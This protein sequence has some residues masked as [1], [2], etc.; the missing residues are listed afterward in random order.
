MLLLNTLFLVLLAFSDLAAAFYP[1][2]PEYRCIYDHT[3]PATKRDLESSLKIVQRLPKVFLSSPLNNGL[4]PELQV[5]RLA[6]RLTKKYQIKRGTNTHTVVAAATPSDTDSAGI[7]QDG[8]DYSYFAQVQLGSGKTPVYLLLDTGASQSWVMGPDCTSAPCLNHNSFGAPNSTTF[9][10]VEGSSWSVKYGSGSC[11]GSYGNDSLSFAG[12]TLPVTIGIANVTSNDFSNFPMDG[13][14][15]LSQASE[16][17]P[18]FTQSL[19]ASKT[20]KSNL[21]AMSLNRDSDGPNTG[22]ISFGSPDNTKYT[23]DIDY[24]SVSSNANGDWAISMDGIGFNGKDAG[25]TGK[26]AYIDTG[27]SYIFGPPS[28]VAQ[29]HAVVPG[30][31]SGDDYTYTVPCTTTVPLTFTFSG[32]TYN[33][34]SEDW[35]SPMAN[36][37]CTSNVFGNDIVAGQWLLGDTF[38][39]NVYTVFDIDGSRVGLALKPASSSVTSATSSGISSATGG[40]TSSMATSSITVSAGTTGSLSKTSSDSGPTGSPS[41]SSATATTTG[42]ATSSE[43]GRPGLNGHETPDSSG[44]A[45][46]ESSISSTA[47]P[48]ASPTKKSASSRLDISL[49]TMFLL[50]LAFLTL[51]F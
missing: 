50:A 4:S 39:K 23:G 31:A 9:E 45:A 32:V 47:S 46:A 28:E 38:L 34:S 14:L 7:D 5:R 35:V 37:V 25:V 1:F 48:T 18:S 43:T 17:F 51:S 3:C 22:E 15:G 29:F 44:T 11:S 16:Q 30:A 2:I 21:F 36:G 10:E 6:E 24:S 19:V 33:V 41:T 12:L 20:L 40:Q 49:P 42:Q 13:I 27:T 8:T 26:I